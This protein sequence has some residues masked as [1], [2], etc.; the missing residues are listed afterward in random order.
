MPGLQIP[1]KYNMLFKP[2]SATST[3]ATGFTQAAFWGNPLSTDNTYSFTPTVILKKYKEIDKGRKEFSA[4]GKDRNGKAVVRGELR[5]LQSDADKTQAGTRGP[6][7]APVPLD[8]VCKIAWGKKTRASLRSE[9]SIYTA[10]VALQG[11]QIPQLYGVF[12]G[13]TDEGKIGCIVMS[14]EGERLQELDF[15]AY[16]Q[17][18]RYAACL[19]GRAHRT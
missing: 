14:Y 11:K 6:G 17:N 18:V 10:L 5:V 19:L 3:L 4:K 16:N 7:A 2:K 8:V 15:W 1:S 12:H 13:E 9:V